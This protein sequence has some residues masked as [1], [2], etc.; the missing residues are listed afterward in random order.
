MIG[1]NSYLISR[2]MCHIKIDQYIVQYT[3][4]GEG[5]NVLIRQAWGQ[6]LNRTQDNSQLRIIA[7]ITAKWT[8]SIISC[9]NGG[10]SQNKN[11]CDIFSHLYSIA[12]HRLSL[13][14]SF[15]W[16]IL[17]Q[18]TPNMREDTYS[19]VVDWSTW[20][21]EDFACEWLKESWLRAGKVLADSFEWVMDPSV[22][23]SNCWKYHQFSPMNY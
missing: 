17:P 8:K 19:I 7:K 1:P 20:E 4:T 3:Y 15:S 5:K 13:F 14:H 23:L 21:S 9:Q 12:P 11:S 18:T 6:K 10:I 2:Y 22:G 16:C